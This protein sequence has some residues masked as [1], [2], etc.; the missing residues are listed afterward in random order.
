MVN[1]ARLLGPAVAGGVIAGVGEGYCFLIDGFSYMAVIA[2]LLMMSI[3]LAAQLSR[4]RPV[5]DELREG[6]NY[7]ANFVPVRSILLLLIV[8]SLMGMPFTILM[9]I[10]A[11]K[12]LQ[13][14]A[15]TLGFLMGSVGVGA[16]ISAAYLAARRTV[17]GLGRVVAISAAIFGAGLLL[18]ALSK[19]LWLSM[20]LLVITGAGMMQQ[21]AG[22]NTILQTI[23]DD[24]KRGRVMS[25][26]S[27]AIMGMTPFGSLLAGFL[28]ARIGAPR[29]L[30]V[31]GICCIAGAAWFLRALPALRAVVRPIYIRLGILPEVAS[32][33]QH[34]TALAQD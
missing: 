28:A 22:S 20:V 3:P 26:Y 29:T 16:L 30:I 33:I 27:M 34:A 25:F 13:G 17:L 23:V 24:D 18:F 6:W 32:G 11:A 12:V 9:P 14:G 15:H 5:L 8:V 4:S 1:G 7:V 10:F 21:M 2:S 31:G 19:H